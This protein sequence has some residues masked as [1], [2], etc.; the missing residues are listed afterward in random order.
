MSAARADEAVTVVSEL[1][2][3]WRDRL[4]ILLGRRVHHRAVVAP[5]GEVVEACL[6]VDPLIAPRVAALSDSGGR[7]AKGGAT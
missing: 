1:T 2:F 6:W 4:L 5:T 3:S 7:A